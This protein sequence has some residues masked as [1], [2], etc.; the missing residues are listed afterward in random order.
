MRNF[1]Y[2]KSFLIGNNHLLIWIQNPTVRIFFRFS[3]S[4]P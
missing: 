2:E 4:Y 1:K 3:L